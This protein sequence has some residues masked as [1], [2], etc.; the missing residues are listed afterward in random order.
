MRD[1]L[2]TLQDRNV[3]VLGISPD[4]PQRQKKFAEKHELPYP[5]L[6]DED[7][8]VA[9]AFGVWREKKVRGK[10]TMGIVRSAFLFD[11]DG[12]LVHAWY[13]ISPKDTV[14]KLLEVLDG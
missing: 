6:S 12:N 13:R 8:M 4:S 5:L 11:E 2:P 3:K 9:E 14:P 7:H 1:A 10:V